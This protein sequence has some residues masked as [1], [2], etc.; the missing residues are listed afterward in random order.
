MIAAKTIAQALLLA[1]CVAACATRPTPDVNA[2][3]ARSGSNS[4]E[5]FDGRVDGGSALVLPVVHDRQIEGAACGAHALA[6]VVN[7]W[8]GAGT[9]SGAQLY[10]SAPPADPAH[11]YSIA[12]IMALASQQGLLASGVRLNLPELIRELDNGRPVLVPVRLPSIYVQDRSLPQTSA[13]ALNVAR[14]VVMDR[15]GRVSEMTDLAV[16]DHYL[17]LVGYDRDRFVVVEPV[18]GFRTISFERLARYRREFDDAA[19]VF[20]GPERPASA[21]QAG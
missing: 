9:V 19:V 20:S 5:P 12:E 3:A 16:V 14:G 13:A 7:Y 17:L 10:A 2:F 8:R 21:V 1:L 18:M 11:G 6:S 4:F 15:M